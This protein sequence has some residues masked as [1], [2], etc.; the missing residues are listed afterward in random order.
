MVNSTQLQTTSAAIIAGI[1]GFL[2]GRGIFG[3]DQATWITV[4]TS[5]AGVVVLIY[6]AW[7]T[8]GSAIVNQAMSA[9][10]PAMVSAV[11]NLPEVKSIEVDKNDPAAKALVAATPENVVSA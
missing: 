7:V 3:W 4:I 1:A 9:D 5:L 10:K 6:N 8:R 2:A 11:A